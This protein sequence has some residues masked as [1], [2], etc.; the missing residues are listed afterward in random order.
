MQKDN[1]LITLFIII[2]TGIIFLLAILIIMLLFFYQKRKIAYQEKVN[3]MKLDFEKNLLSTQI[4][5]QEQTLL[6][7][8]REIHD[9]ICLSLTLAKLN[10]NTLDWTD[11]ATSF[12]SVKS[13][14]QIL[15]NSISD[16]NN[17]S[18]GMNTELIRNLGLMKAVKNEIQRIEQMACLQIVYEIKGDPIFMDCEKELVIFRIIQEAF[19]NIVK[20][21]QASKVWLQLDYSASYLDIMIKDNGIG[22]SHQPNLKQ[23][24]ISTA[25]L[26]NMKTRAKIFGGK[27]LIESQVQ[28]GT[29]I[30]VTV[31]YN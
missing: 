10:L 2:T 14:V 11:V 3:S 7:I 26:N 4:E 22:F 12:K 9:N 8:S 5:I 16:L 13:S 30:L 29:Q 1:S 25:G 24:E 21:A 31:P 28:V 6:H 23:N 17:L 27:V 20:H 19:N 15:G 18:K